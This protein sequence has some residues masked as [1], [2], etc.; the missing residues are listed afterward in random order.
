MDELRI[1]EVLLNEC[2]HLLTYDENMQHRG[3]RN[4]L[5]M[6]AM[7]GYRYR[8]NY[9]VVLTHGDFEP[10]FDE[11]YAHYLDLKA[12]GED[13]KWDMKTGRMKE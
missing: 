5:E 8:S 10:D 11:N 7:A 2:L 9:R 3:L 6:V 1:D 4:L 13:V 12:Q